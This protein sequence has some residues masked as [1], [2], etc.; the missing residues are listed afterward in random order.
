MRFFR[1]LLADFDPSG[2]IGRAP[3]SGVKAE[4][5]EKQSAGYGIDFF[6]LV[7]EAHLVTGV[8]FAA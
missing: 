2:R 4:R 6:V 7:P 3:A 1:A 5:P 8:R